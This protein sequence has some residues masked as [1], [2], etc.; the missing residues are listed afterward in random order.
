MEV[1]AGRFFDGS[2]CCDDE[3][4]DDDASSS[5]SLSRHPVATVGGG[6]G[7]MTTVNLRVRIRSFVRSLQFLVCYV[8]GTMCCGFCFVRCTY[9]CGRDWTM[10]HGIMASRSLCEIRGE[11]HFHREHGRYVKPASKRVGVAWR[12]DVVSNFNTSAT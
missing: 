1:K 2:C 5:L 4:D 3:C 8:S 12:P 6:V 11:D 7:G 10:D 9:S